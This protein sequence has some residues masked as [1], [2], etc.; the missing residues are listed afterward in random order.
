MHANADR[1][2]VT[3]RR[4]GESAP[5]RSASCARLDAA[6]RLAWELR[7]EHPGGIIEAERSDG[8]RYAFATD[9]GFRLVAMPQERPAQLF[10]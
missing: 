6:E 1:Y 8:A 7:S 5:Y 2:S 3:V 4:S 10:A 9:T